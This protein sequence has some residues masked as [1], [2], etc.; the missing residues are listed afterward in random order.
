MLVIGTEKSLYAVTS[1]TGEVLW[2]RKDARLYETDVAAVPGT[3]VLL[4]SFERGDKTRLEAV[5]LLTGG[6]LW[7]GDKAHGSVMQMAF[8]PGSGL[9][10]VV[11]VRDARGRARGEFKRKAV[12]QAFDLR[13]GRELW[14]RELD[15]EVEMMPALLGVSEDEDLPYTLDNYRPPAFFDGRLYLF[16]E[17]V[18]SLDARTGEERRREKFRVNEEGLALTEAD[19][20]A[21][22]R[23]V[24]FSGR[25][26]RA[27]H[28]A[29]RRPR[30][31]GGQRPGFDAGDRAGWRSAL[32]A[33]GRAVHAPRRRRVGGARSIRSQRH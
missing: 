9:L 11:V 3:D 1:E 18:T 15:S 25:G 13:R 7:R 4:L 32:C 26:P 12:V 8:D 2:R 14:K 28:L 10:A 27:R 22:E 29:G 20:V 6:A 31:V 16:Y 19:P 5:D 24:Y 33:D 17:G 23:F 30:G 21:D